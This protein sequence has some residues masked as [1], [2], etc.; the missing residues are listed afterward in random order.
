M[1]GRYLNVPVSGRTIGGAATA[2]ASIGPAQGDFWTPSMVRVTTQP[3]PQN[4]PYTYIPRCDLYH[5]PAG[6]YT[7]D[8]LIDN[9]YLGSGDV[10]TICSGI[11]VEPGQTLTA[12]WTNDDGS[13]SFDT[14]IMTVYGRAFDNLQ[15]L[16]N[17]FAPVPGAR[18]SGSSANALIWDWGAFALATST[19][20][21]NNNLL[22]APTA[23][24]PIEVMHV[25]LTV[26]TDAT[27]GN[28]FIGL[29]CVNNNIN[30]N[31]MSTWKINTGFA[32]TAST[33]TKYTFTA[34]GSSFGVAG[35]NSLG[36]G[37]PLPPQPLMKA[38]AQINVLAAGTLGAGDVRNT[39]K[40]TY[41]QY[42]GWSKAGY[43]V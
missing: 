38:G 40:I 1:P 8:L 35:L 11:V 30:G 7:P 42:R 19:P 27:A 10:S 29:E 12:I 5:G 34:G 6:S 15:E 2:T 43:F 9:T 4:N 18:F 14:G 22:F 36:V 3:F 39:L 17:E 21:T 24:T 26:V 13:T 31:L 16:Q 23:P 37:A 28:R 33:T 20:L 25:E 41:K 32:Q